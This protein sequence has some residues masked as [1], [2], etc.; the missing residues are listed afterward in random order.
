LTLKSD[1]GLNKN[2]V[3]IGETFRLS[4]SGGKLDAWSNIVLTGD[5]GSE[6][7]NVHTSCSVRIVVGD[8]YGSLQIVG[9]GTLNGEIVCNEA[10]TPTCSV[11]TILTPALDATVIASTWKDYRPP[12]KAWIQ[13]RAGATA[14]NADRWV[15][16]PSAT[17]SLNVDYNPN[18]NWQRYCPKNLSVTWTATNDCGG[19]PVTAVFTA[20]DT[21]PPPITSHATSVFVASDGNG[22]QAEYLA[23]WN[24][25]GGSTCGG[26]CKTGWTDEPIV[27]I[28]PPGSNGSPPPLIRYQNKATCPL[29]SLVTWWYKDNCGNFVQSSATFTILEGQYREPEVAQ[30]TGNAELPVLPAASEGKDLL[31][32]EDAARVMLGEGEDSEQFRSSLAPLAKTL[33]TALEGQAYA[34]PIVHTETFRETGSCPTTLQFTFTAEDG[35]GSF[36]TADGLFLLNDTSP[37]VA[38]RAPENVQVEYD[39]AYDHAETIDAWLA[40]PIFVDATETTVTHALSRVNT[41]AGQEQCLWEATYTFSVTDT[42]GNTYVACCM[43]HPA[44]AVTFAKTLYTDTPCFVSLESSGTQPMRRLR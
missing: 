37:P 20:V 38:Q 12:M 43:H 24:N 23:W 39:P 16:N 6:D 13:S 4:A 25:R 10:Y 26:D 33:M 11:P 17:G 2:R 41:V 27:V 34:N 42:C 22:N 30:V 15:K 1:G 44:T 28:D 21:T 14:A 35:C 3:A 29:F 31:M 5:A 19:S 8:R 7:L 40:A 9:L 36:I 32:E 18:T